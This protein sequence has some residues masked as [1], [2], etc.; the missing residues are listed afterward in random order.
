VREACNWPFF[1]LAFILNEN[2]SASL[3]GFLAQLTSADHLPSKSVLVAAKACGINPVWASAT[4]DNKTG[5]RIFF[6]VMNC[7]SDQPASN[8]ICDSE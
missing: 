5:R 6:V 7:H 2:F 3:A 4:Q 1:T 8:L